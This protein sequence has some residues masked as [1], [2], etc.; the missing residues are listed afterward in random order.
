MARADVVTQL[1][2]VVPA[3]SGR[4]L[5]AGLE[6]ALARLPVAT[7]LLVPQPE[8]DTGALLP[9]IERIQAKGVA[10]LVANNAGLAQSLKADGVHI[11]PSKTLDVQ[12]AEARGILGSHAIVGADAGRSRHDAMSMGEAGADYVAFGIPPHVEDRETARRRRLELVAWWC[13]IFEIPCVAFDVDTPDDA[14]DLAGAGAD[15]VAIELPDRLTAT[16]VAQYLMPFA[17]AVSLPAIA[18]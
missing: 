7:V 13:E 16:E 5:M 2:L 10:A 4:D 18:V 17:T 14:A 12:V 9:L 6:D 11:T 15:F 8:T 1:Y 3:R